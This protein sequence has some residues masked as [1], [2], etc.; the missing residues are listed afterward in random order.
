[1]L[2]NPADLKNKDVLIE[3]ALN[4]PMIDLKKLRQYTWC[5]VPHH[6]RN[7]IYR[8]LFE[9]NSLQNS[10]Y[11]KEIIE[12]NNVYF[13]K[14]LNVNEISGSSSCYVSHMQF[15]VDID[16]K[17]AK[18][19]EIDVDRIPSQ[20]LVYNNISLQFIYA[21]ILKVVAKRRPAIGYVQGMADLLIPL[22][23]IYKNEFFVESTVYATFSKLLDTFQDYFVDGQQ[24]ITKA[25]KKFKK[26]LR[27]VD[28]ILYTHIINIGLELH[29][30]AFRWFNCL[31]VREFKIEYYLLFLDSMLATSNYEL[32]VIYFAVS[33]IVN[34][35]KEILSRDFN[36]VLLFLQ[37]LNEL[38]W[39]YTELKILFASVYVNVNV[40]EEKFYYEF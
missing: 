33:L 4:S 29:M 27:M 6:H 5:G 21:N 20:H 28:P 7:K 18:Q 8:L 34:L 19:I 22:I 11:H 30:F 35:R 39:E 17:I 24:G 23:E 3:N 10:T 40:F 15:K 9:V 36:D 38:D 37:S 26:I 25:I 12:N 13:Q 14:I 2:Y 16:R 31:F 1:M 32:F